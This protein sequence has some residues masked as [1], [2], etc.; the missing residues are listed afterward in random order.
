M[1]TV[2][3][4]SKFNEDGSLTIPREVVEKLGLHPGDEVQVRIEATDEANDLEGPEQAALQA[5]F[6]RFFAEL[7]TLTFEKPTKFPDGDQ[8]ET[9]FTE[10]MDKKYRKLG[11]K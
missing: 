5:K 6:E 9:A 8:A 11:F 2:T 1:T 7:D 4:A 3:F 10:I